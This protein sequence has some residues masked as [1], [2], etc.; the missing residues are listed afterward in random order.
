MKTTL[1]LQGNTVHAF[2]FR[3]LSFPII[4]AESA[5]QAVFE[6]QTSKWAALQTATC[7]NAFHQLG[8]CEHPD[9]PLVDQIPDVGPEYSAPTPSSVNAK[10][11][12]MRKLS[13]RLISPF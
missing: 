12:Y 9:F 10:L 11:I 3:F 7:F 6:R 13:R 5:D 2:C 1:S 4:K 8:N